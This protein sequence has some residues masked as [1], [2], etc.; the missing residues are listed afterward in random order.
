MIFQ[1]KPVHITANFCYTQDERPCGE[2][3]NCVVEITIAL[4]DAVDKK[5]LQTQD[6]LSTIK[7]E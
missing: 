2:I 5:R 7:H 1:L 4:N 6:H 3:C